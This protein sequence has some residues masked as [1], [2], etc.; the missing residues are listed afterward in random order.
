WDERLIVSMQLTASDLSSRFLDGLGV[1]H[2]RQGVILQTADT[3]FL[4]EEACSGIRSLFSTW[5]V[6]AIASIA[7]RHRW[8]RLGINMIQ[9]VPWVLIGNVLRIVA[10]VGLSSSYPWLA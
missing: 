4:T 5:A 8:W 3:R 7:L 2:F 9:T 1:I 10:V 6:V